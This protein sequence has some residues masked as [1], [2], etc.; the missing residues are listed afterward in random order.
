MSDKDREV[1]VR[2]QSLVSRVVPPDELSAFEYETELL[3][4]LQNNL[5]IVL[6]N[7]LLVAI[8]ILRRNG[9]VDEVYGPWSLV[10]GQV[11]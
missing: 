5:S 9:Y 10:T 2:L 4:A 11:D 8:D 7:Y 6:D 3:Q 1:I